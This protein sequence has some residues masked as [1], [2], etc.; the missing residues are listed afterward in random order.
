MMNKNKKQMT[1]RILNHTL[2]IIYLLTGEDYI[3]VKKHGNHVTDSSSPCVPERFCRTQRPIME[4]PTNSLI[5]ERNNDKKL[6]SEK[7]LEHT[8]IIIHLL[9][10]EVPIKCDDIAVYFSMEEWDYLDGHKD[11]YKDMMME[12]HKNLSSLDKSISRSTPAGGHTPLCSPDRV[13]EDN[14]VVKSDQGTNY[15]RQNNPSK[16]QRKA[17]RIIAKE[18]DSREEENPTVSHNYTPK[19]HERVSTHIKK[20]NKG[21][22]NAQ[23]IHK[24]LSG[25]KYKCSECGKNYNKKSAYT[26][27]QRTHTTER[28]HKCSECQKCFTCNSALVKHQTIHKEVKLFPCS[29]CG[30]DISCKSVLLR[31]KRIHRAEKRFSC[32]KCGKYFAKNANLVA[33]QRVHTGERPFVCSTCGKCFSKNSDVVRHQRV[34]TG[35][36]PFGCSECGKGFSN[37]SDLVRHHMIHTGQ[38]PFAC[39]ECGKCFSH[40][41][42]L[43]THKRVHTGEKPFVCSACGKCFYQ[44]SDLLKHQ[45][46]HAVEK[47][48][49]CS[50]CGKCFFRMSD[51][52]RHQIIHTGEKSFFCSECGKCFFYSTNLVKHQ[53]IHT[54]KR[55]IAPNV[56]NVLHKVQNLLNIR[57]T[58]A[59]NI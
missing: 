53:R 49:V 43:V 30:K 46:V 6:M 17:V 28:L 41:S 25:M 29:E 3:V 36:K 58:T 42:T 45:S 40:S 39:S 21:N 31:H 8:N 26:I 56:G 59:K 54:R 18:S 51:L 57:D 1:E 37:K 24:N 34:H 32:S 5:H 10:G 12:N 7:I 20:C 2:E 44:N 11:R 23:K 19:E 13:N 15:L 55:L 27:H 33:H 16:R 4:N 35:E 47:P 38:K 48:F 52:V 9:T 14:G 22:T 50:E